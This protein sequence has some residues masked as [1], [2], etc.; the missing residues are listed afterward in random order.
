MR[1]RRWSTARAGRIANDIAVLIDGYWLRHTRSDDA[2][3]AQAAIRQIEDFVDDKL[4]TAKRTGV[5]K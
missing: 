3:D 4:A 5:S 2:V 1:L